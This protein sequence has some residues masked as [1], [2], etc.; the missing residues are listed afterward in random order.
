MR[1]Y[2]A[3][4]LVICMMWLCGCAPTTADL[5]EPIRLYYLSNN[6]LQTDQSFYAVQSIEGI[7]FQGDAKQML[8]AYFNP[9]NAGNC[10]FP[11]P[12]NLQVI[13]VSPTESGTELTL[14]SDFATLEGID[15]TLACAC[16]TMTLCEYLQINSV[17]ISAQGTQLAGKASI[18]IH[19]DSLLLWDNTP[20]PETASE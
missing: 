15:L 11:F 2:L 6:N 20:I 3:L 18:T 17:T 14:S 1:K 13:T 10:V 9:E 5:N 7:D 16:I 8:A 19:K 4:G 12:D